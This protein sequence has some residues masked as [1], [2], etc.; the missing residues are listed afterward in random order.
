MVCI[1]I[2]VRSFLDVDDDPVRV[3][4]RYG[5]DRRLDGREVPVLTRLVDVDFL[6][7]DTLI[8]A[9]HFHPRIFVVANFQS[10]SRRRVYM[11]EEDADHEDAHQRENHRGDE[12]KISGAWGRNRI[13]TVTLL[14]F[15][16]DGGDVIGMKSIGIWRDRACVYAVARLSSAIHM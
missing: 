13:G 11:E 4:A 7:R 6:V 2:P 15:Y 12:S 14:R 16:K 10:S 3:V 1:Y 5:V 9:G 8:N